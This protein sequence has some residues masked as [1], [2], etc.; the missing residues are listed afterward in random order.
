M[1]CK[2]CSVPC[3]PFNGHLCSLHKAPKLPLPQVRPSL[4]SSLPIPLSVNGKHQLVPVSN[5]T[6]ALLELPPPISLPNKRLA[7]KNGSV[8]KPVVSENGSDLKFPESSLL[9]LATRKFIQTNGRRIMSDAFA[10]PDNAYT[11]EQ[12]KL[13][14]SNE[15]TVI[16]DDISLFEIETQLKKV[17]QKPKPLLIPNG[18]V[19]IL[20]NVRTINRLV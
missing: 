14:L 8:D 5:G 20:Q 1:A 12:K 17:D 18:P 16:D 19:A 13:K 15:C 10:L 11:V 9:S 6:K 7:L 3:L 2:S 4:T